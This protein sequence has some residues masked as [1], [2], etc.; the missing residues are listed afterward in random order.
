MRLLALEEFITEEFAKKGVIEGRALRPIAR[1]ARAA[2]G[3]VDHG[4]LDG[5]GDLNKALGGTAGHWLLRNRRQG[6]Y[7]SLRLRLVSGGAARHPADI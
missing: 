6:A 4:G 2:G 5:F 7:N 1:F 3:D